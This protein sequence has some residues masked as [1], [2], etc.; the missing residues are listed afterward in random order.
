MDY[1]CRVRLWL[2]NS[3]TASGSSER[4]R[5]DAEPLRHL[6]FVP[7]LL[8]SIFTLFCMPSSV[9]L[10]SF[11]LAVPMRKCLGKHQCM[12]YTFSIAIQNGTCINRSP[13]IVFVLFGACN[14]TKNYNNKLFL[15]IFFRIETYWTKKSLK[16][17]FSST[18]ISLVRLGKYRFS[19]TSV[20]VIFHTEFQIVHLYCTV[21]KKHT[22][23]VTRSNNFVS[24]H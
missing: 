13:G 17:N 19:T 9:S 11:I 22:V 18:S 21:E 10:S 8:L 15:C 20:F 3:S 23:L 16:I 7:T 4:P 2:C 14:E 5:V 12:S 1:R 6:Y 24:L